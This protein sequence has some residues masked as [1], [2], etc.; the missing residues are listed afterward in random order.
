MFQSNSQDSTTGSHDACTF[1]TDM[2]AMVG[3]TYGVQYY[4][5][6]VLGHQLFVLRE[7]RAHD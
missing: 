1:S 4:W 6:W 3:C 5:P 2:G 7:N